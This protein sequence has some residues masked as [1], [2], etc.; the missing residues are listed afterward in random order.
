LL[1]A[2]Q[3][4]KFSR[5]EFLKGWGATDDAHEV[6]ATA[7]GARIDSV[8]V[9]KHKMQ[10]NRLFFQ[11]KKDTTAFFTGKTVKGDPAF[12]FLVFEGQGK[13]QVGVRMGDLAVAGVILE[14]LRQAVQ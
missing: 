6:V 1:P 14:L 7:E 9:A 4:G 11:V 8:D 13:V 3:G 10:E 12:V 5:D 2:D